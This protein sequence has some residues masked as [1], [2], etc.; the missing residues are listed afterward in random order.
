MI[1]KD[2]IKPKWQH[3]DPE[4]RLRAVEAMASNELELLGRLAAEDEAPAVR[5]AALARLNDPDLVQ[6]L[7]T[8]DADPATRQFAKERLLNLVAGTAEDCPALDVRTGFL[9]RSPAGELAEFVA[10]NGIEP[11]LRRSA[12][13]RVT[14]Q[15][16]LRD[17]ATQDVVL[18]N[19]E[20]ALARIEDPERLEEVVQR[21][22]K[23]DKQIHRQ[24]KERLEAMRAAEKRRCFVAEEAEHLCAALES[25]GREGDWR[26]ALDRLPELDDRW[27]RVKGESGPAFQDRFDR[28][29][30]AFLQASQPAREA[31]EAEARERAAAIAGKEALLTRAEALHKQLQ[32][33]SGLT[34][35]EQA[36]CALEVETLQRAWTETEGLPPA[37]AQPLEERFADAIRTIANRLQLLVQQRKQAAALQ[38]LRVEAERLAE[39]KQPILEKDV[40]S[41]EKRWR[42]AL[43]PDEQEKDGDTPKKLEEIT[44][45]L[46]KRLAHQRH[47]RETKFEL[48][49]ALITELE[50]LLHENRVKEAA[51]LHD[52][53]LSSINHLQALGVPKQQLR[54]HID[55][56]HR[57]DPQLLEL[58]SWQAW[59][60]DDVRERLC[61]EMESM[62]G[63]ELAPA[64]L[65][66]RI[67][68]LRSEWNQLRSDGGAGFRTMRRRFDKAAEQAYAPCERHFQ[69]QAQQREGNLEKKRRLLETL[70]TY[71][72]S[73]EWPPEDWKEAARF[74]RRI[75]TQWRQAGPVDRRKS[76]EINLAFDKRLEV[77]NT[78]L[79]AERKRNLE[80]RNALI[81]EVR[82]L[83][84]MEDIDSAINRCK[85][86]Q[87]SW[88]VTVPGTRKKENA[89]WQRFREACDAVFLRRQHQQAALHEAEAQ[90]RAERIRLCEQAERLVKCG[91]GEL[92]DATR[93][94][95]KIEGDWSALPATARR[96]TDLDKRFDGART[97]FQAHVRALRRQEDQDQLARLRVKAGHCREMEKLL[98]D[99]DAAGTQ[100]AVE[101]LDEA[102]QA[103]GPLRDDTTERAIRA[104][105]EKAMHAV[106]EGGR[107]RE[108][109]LGELRDNRGLKE[110]LCLRMEILCGVESPPEAR[111]ARLAFQAD[112]L[113]K[114]ISQGSEDPI[115]NIND[116]EREWCLTGG[117]PTAWETRLQE[118]FEAACKAGR[119]R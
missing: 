54:T 26:E 39:S 65:A 30:D 90:R 32:G 113:A 23:S 98:H 20:A 42:E 88:R 16:V 62:I 81:D 31:L 33:A 89:V 29:R 18:A 24:S 102:W 101:A 119:S 104:R 3:R 50:T 73:V 56:L 97:A 84:E 52:R 53:I 43:L 51:P 79:E 12:L 4:T 74:Q 86:L 41:L 116:I 63:S 60:A 11:E 28:A 108:E 106:V 67:R 2:F 99:P 85:A 46:R 117:E 103:Q 21:T 35:S 8:K 82:A 36:A 61:A 64:E 45:R 107:R 15:T 110:R 78:H 71:L 105:F 118:R 100:A 44:A 57:M 13:E 1:L 94:F 58:R 109:L 87:K 5:R 37:A 69:A 75:T 10:L 9:A 83:A 34:E 40:K 80:Q 17:A 76:K 49:P 115:G 77:L 55:K 112:R 68:H 25:M 114:A 93:R 22:R 70:D 111:E 95:H 92:D 47:Q 38:S 7:S 27:E 14:G 48:L 66:A 19:R 59:A 96:N 91:P 6:R 72:A